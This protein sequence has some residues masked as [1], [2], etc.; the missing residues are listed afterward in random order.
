MGAF[1]KFILILV[2][3]SVLFPL[4]GPYYTGSQPLEVIFP[5]PVEESVDPYFDQMVIQG[6]YLTPLKRAVEIANNGIDG[7]ASAFIISSVIRHYTGKELKSYLGTFGFMVLGY[8]TLDL[9]IPVLGSTM[10]FAAI[11][12]LFHMSLAGSLLAHLAYALVRRVD[13]AE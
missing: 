1:K 4:V 6:D 2:A 8:M 7:V 10:L 11:L 13:D 3:I 9:F 12:M 5:T